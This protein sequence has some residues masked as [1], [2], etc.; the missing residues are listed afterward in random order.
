MTIRIG[1]DVACRALHR[2]ACAD[3]TGK[4]LWCNVRF[5]TSAEDLE[6]R[7]QRLPA[8]EDDITAVMEPTGNAWVPLVA[9]FLR[10]GAR[11]V[12]VPPKQSADLRAY[13]NKPPASAKLSRHQNRPPGGPF[14]DP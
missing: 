10:H 6:E 11:G 9:W 7:W 5:P 1:I 13:Y 4:L 12:M 2:A 3:A 14:H 8:G